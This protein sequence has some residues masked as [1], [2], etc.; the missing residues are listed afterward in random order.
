[1]RTIVSL[2]LGCATT[3]SAQSPTDDVTGVAK[4][5]IRGALTFMP[6]TDDGRVVRAL[7]PRFVAADKANPDLDVGP[8]R[9]SASTAA[10]AASIGAVVQDPKAICGA[11]GCSLG[12]LAGYVSLS[13]PT[14]RGDWATISVSVLTPN[15]RPNAVFYESYRFGVARQHGEWHVRVVEVLGVPDRRKAS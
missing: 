10:I 6:R 14:I 5:A 11:S 9:D 15:P 8:E 2:L 4:A 3:L 1:M 12:E 7:N 13:E